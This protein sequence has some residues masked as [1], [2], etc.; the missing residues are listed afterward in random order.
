MNKS[1]SFER[2]LQVPREKVMEVAADV[3]FADPDLPVWR[4]RRLVDYDRGRRERPEIGI[5]EAR[6]VLGL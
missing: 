3:L 2:M 4:K 1:T 5:R 6:R